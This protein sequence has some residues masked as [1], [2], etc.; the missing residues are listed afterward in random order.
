[1]A[2]WEQQETLILWAFLLVAFVGLMVATLFWLIYQYQRKA[3]QDRLD[4]QA[5][6]FEFQDNLRLALIESQEH[7][8]ARIAGELHDAVVG[9]LTA[10]KWQLELQR[11]DE[12]VQQQLEACIQEARSISHDLYPP[13]LAEKSLNELM[14]DTVQRWNPRIASHWHYSNPKGITTAVDVKLHL[15]R[16]VQ[17]LLVNS[18]K[19]GEATIV[20]LILRV[21]EKAI[22][23]I[24]QDNGKG[25]I[26]SSGTGLGMRSIQHRVSRLAGTHKIKSRTGFVCVL[27]CPN[28]QPID[29]HISPPSSIPPYASSH[30]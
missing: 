20:T 29:K 23:L 12:K 18:D 15:I 13:L 22:S 28:N 24:Y 30:R 7:E 10:I 8:R 2:L 1:M 16:I 11:G 14:I 4:R 5:L 3:F 17:E 6:H 9:H 21:T 19:H 26:Q 25:F 27:Y